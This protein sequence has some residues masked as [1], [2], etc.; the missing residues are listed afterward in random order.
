MDIQTILESVGYG[1][2]ALAAILLFTVVLMRILAP[3]NVFGTKWPR[4]GAFKA[5]SKAGVLPSILDGDKEP[6][7]LNFIQW[8]LFKTIRV[9]WI[10]IPGFVSIFKDKMWIRSLEINEN[11]TATT[12]PAQ[13]PDSTHVAVRKDVMQEEFTKEF[14]LAFPLVTE[15]INYAVFVQYIMN[16]WFKVL[17]GKELDALAARRNHPDWDEEIIGKFINVLKN[18]ARVKS[19]DD[20]KKE[21]PQGT[22]DYYKKEFQELNPFLRKMFFI[23]FVDSDQVDFTVRGKVVEEESKL[24]VQEVTNQVL[25]KSKEGQRDAKKIEKETAIIEKEIKILENDAEVDLK[26][27]LKTGYGPYKRTQALE[28]TTLSTLVEADSGSKAVTAISTTPKTST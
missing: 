2:G 10:G 24:A 5:K 20:L 26:N 1:V 6:A 22:H 9:V 12:D 16:L 27:R 7:K 4:A 13:I 21:K 8:L 15:T 11:P 14:Q 25:I 18:H 17:P 3:L 28:K 19:A 23:E